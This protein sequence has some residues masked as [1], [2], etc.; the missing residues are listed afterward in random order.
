MIPRVTERCGKPDFL[1]CVYGWATRGSLDNG[2]GF[3]SH[4]RC[5]GLC[6]LKC[7]KATTN[8]V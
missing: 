4:D 6:F 8:K 1:V 3:A 7:E 2:T 5:D